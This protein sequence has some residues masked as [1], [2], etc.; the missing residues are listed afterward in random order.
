LVGYILKMRLSPNHAGWV[1][2]LMGGAFAGCLLSAD[3]DNLQG[4]EPAAQ[5]DADSDAPGDSSSARDDGA[6]VDAP[7]SDAGTSPGCSAADAQFCADFDRGALSDGWTRLEVTGGDASRDPATFVSPPYSFVS[8]TPSLDSA[9]SSKARL[10]KEFGLTIS[11]V[12][13]R[14]RVRI[15]AADPNNQDAELVSVAFL[16]GTNYTLY[17]ML[18][19]GG[20]EL[21]EYVPPGDAAGSWT[22]RHAL[23][24]AIPRGAWTTVSV[25]VSLTVPAVSVS[26][27]GSEVLDTAITPGKT[28]ASPVL[29]VGTNATGPS[30][31]WQV[32]IDDV[33]FDSR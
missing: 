8:S 12:H 18:R 33:L 11:E 13:L 10:V 30:A 4:G 22:M 16:P 5:V 19:S 27:E 15:D 32:H 20:D 14:M 17:L 26:I 23:K 25:D 6:V 31:P 2:F 3:F 9:G 24:G 21:M 1:P 7:T 29:R 28:S